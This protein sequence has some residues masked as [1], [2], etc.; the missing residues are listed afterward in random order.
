M[1]HE[2]R[3][4]HGGWNWRL[5][6]QHGRNRDWNG[7]GGCTKQSG[8]HGDLSGGLH[9]AAELGI[10]FQLEGSDGCLDIKAGRGFVPWNARGLRIEQQRRMGAAAG[11]I[12]LW[13]LS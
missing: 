7:T 12:L 1:L 4:K 13:Q 6:E 8:K 3:G 11:S 5:H 10:R 2:Q 9:R